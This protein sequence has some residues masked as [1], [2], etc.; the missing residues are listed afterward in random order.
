M[1]TNGPA[2]SS[3]RIDAQ[4]RL[5]TPVEVTNRDVIIVFGWRSDTEFYY[6]HL[7]TDNT[8]YPHNGIFKVN[9]ADRERID[10]QWNGRSRAPIRRSPMPTGTACGWCT[11]RP[12]ERSR[13]TSTGTATRC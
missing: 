2:W 8:I 4:V 11:C 3:V 7:S 1:L 13:S 9:N 12:P 10:H 6:A 5:D